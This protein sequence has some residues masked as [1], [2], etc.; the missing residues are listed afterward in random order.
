MGNQL[1]A[2]MPA[3]ASAGWRIPSRSPAAVLAELAGNSPDRLFLRFG[4]REVTF[5]E[6]QHDVAYLADAL[7]G[8]G[9]GQGSRVALA[10]ENCVEHVALIFA[11]FRL[12]A[13][14]VPVNP[15]LRGDP[16]GHL[17]RDA[18]PS[19]VVTRVGS[20]VARQIVR[21][22]LTAA[23]A[24]HAG[25]DFVPGLGADLAVLPLA[26]V[27]R[28]QSTDAGVAAIM[29]TSGTTGPAKGVI[30][31]QRMFWAAALG[32]MVVTDARPGDVLYLWEPVY[33]IGGAQILLIPLIAEVSLALAPA[34]SARRF[35]AD[36]A[37]AGATHIHYLGG[38]LQILQ[39][40]APSPAE[41]SHQVRIGWGAGATGPL[42]QACRERFG[43][44]LHECYGMTETSSVVTVNKRGP[45]YGVGFALPWF[46]VRVA[47]AGESRRT[48]EILVRAKTEGLTT[49][50]Y[51][52]TGAGPG[53]R[54]GEWLATGDIGSVGDAGDL[55]FHGRQTDSVR[56]RG[57][58][59]SAWEIETTFNQHPGVARCAVVGIPAEIGEEEIAMLVVPAPDI[60]VGAHELADWAQ[61]RLADFQIPRYIGIVPGLPLTPSQRVAKKLIRLDVSALVD[62]QT[63][64]EDGGRPATTA[65][66]SGP[67]KAEADR[68]QG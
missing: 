38:I 64:G 39:K 45:E 21:T 60:P 5:A 11:L 53:G 23:D 58:N 17:L 6:M 54:S 1:V 9:V 42:Y 49:P 37:A 31:T 15:K 12:G 59:V 35:W 16:L 51:L 29:Y 47:D 36:V 28:D 63:T 2:G 32:C 44:T 22:G 67:R 65:P 26:T 41:R 52:N 18:A 48:G 13:Q 4:D 24:H 50:G 10:L 40:Q 30:V 68:E 20:E 55:H 33:H 66:A 8:V 57:E 56:H 25:H 7:S 43:I 3:D 61:G 19:H 62:V 46:E 34:F 27:R 14:W